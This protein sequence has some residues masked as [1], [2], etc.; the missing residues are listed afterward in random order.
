MSQVDLRVLRVVYMVLEVFIVSFKQRRSLLRVAC[1]L[2]V[3]GRWWLFVVGWLA[4]VR[5][6]WFVVGFVLFVACC[7]V[8]S[9]WCLVFG[10]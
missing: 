2:L 4:C 7:L 3:V 8:F 9:V 6:L 10:V 1:F 5:C